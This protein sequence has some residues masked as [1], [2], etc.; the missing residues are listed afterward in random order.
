M[1]TFTVSRLL[2]LIALVIFLLEA[3]HVGF[4]GIELV[5]L[6]LAVYMGS[7]LVP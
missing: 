5:G 4:G 6:G 1:R 3:F 7:H 2:V